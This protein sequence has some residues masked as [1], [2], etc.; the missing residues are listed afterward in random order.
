MSSSNQPYVPIP[1]DAMTT[2]QWRAREQALGCIY[3]EQKGCDRMNHGYSLCPGCGSPYC[4]GDA[5]PGPNGRFR[6]CPDCGSSPHE[7]RC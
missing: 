1:S 6:N 2:E 3:C 7:G 4:N 5:C